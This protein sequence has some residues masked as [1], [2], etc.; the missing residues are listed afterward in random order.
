LSEITLEIPDGFEVRSVD[1]DAA[2]YSDV[3]G[4][5]GILGGTSTTLGGRGFVKVL[6]VER[7]SGQQVLLLY[8][9]VSQRSQPVQIIRF[10]SAPSVERDSVATPAPA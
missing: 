1:Y 2:M 5:P 10:R 4:T 6:A 8:E 3:S 7:S 9:N